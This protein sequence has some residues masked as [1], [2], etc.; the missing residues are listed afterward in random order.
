MI[1]VYLYGDEIDNKVDYSLQSYDQGFVK[2]GSSVFIRREFDVFELLAAD[3]VV[4][5]DGWTGGSRG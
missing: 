5:R 4:S 2:S 1:L 3:Q